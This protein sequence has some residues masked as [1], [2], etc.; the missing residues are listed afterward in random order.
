MIRW[1]VIRHSKRMQIL[2][3][4]PSH[5]ISMNKTILMGLVVGAIIVPMI[6]WNLMSTVDAKNPKCNPNPHSDSGPNVG[7][8]TGD[9][10]GDNKG[11]PHDNSGDRGDPHSECDIVEEE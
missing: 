2:K 7:R 4:W 1:S 11:D 8:L 3:C 9:P 5:D 10:H 6:G